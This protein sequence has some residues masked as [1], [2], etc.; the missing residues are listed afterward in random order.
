[1]DKILK[2]QSF[3]QTGCTDS[4]C[5]VQIGRLLNM[6]YMITGTL[7][8]LGSSYFITVSIIDVET[9]RIEQSF[10]SPGFVMVNVEIII[11]DLSGRIIK[12]FYPATT[13][14]NL[15]EIERK[16]VEQDERFEK[17]I[18][19]REITV[20]KAAE[21]E[22]KRIA[23]EQKE[24]ELAE[25]KAEA[26]R[27]IEAQRK[28]ELSQKDGQTNKHISGKENGKAP[29][30]RKRIQ[31]V[32]AVD[33][34]EAGIVIGS[35]MHSAVSHA[36]C[37]NPAELAQ[38]SN[39]SLE[40]SQIFTVLDSKISSSSAVHPLTEKICAGIGFSYIHIPWFQAASFAEEP[41]LNR[42]HSFRIRT[43]IAGSLLKTVLL[44]GGL[45]FSHEKLTDEYT[46]YDYELSTGI[47]FIPHNFL[48]ISSHINNLSHRSLPDFGGYIRFAPVLRR[49]VFF[50]H[51]GMST[52]SFD[53]SYMGINKC[54]ALDSG[55][56]CYISGVNLNMST[57]YSRTVGRRTR[58]LLYAGLLFTVNQDNPGFNAGAGYGIGKIVLGYNFSYSQLFFSTHGI[59]L[60]I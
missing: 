2:E 31:R 33:I 57:G 17:E 30:N 53:L 20:Q 49:S 22:A 35:A 27:L 12:V 36:M 28:Q 21:A 34:T 1:M 11:N 60:K 55:N 42:M 10:R 40:F 39:L 25:Q 44:G 8:K 54:S 48:S 14:E 9:S 19:Q 58:I 7:V 4:E 50:I 37:I 16:S 32:G 46:L 13:A 45:M 3:Q 26:D 52:E 15:K 51:T 59:Y 38:I 24:K 41:Q 6:D 56:A 18:N 23:D 47:I 29:V 5:A 43:G